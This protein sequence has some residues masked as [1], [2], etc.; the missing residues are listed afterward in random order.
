MQNAMPP[1][2]SNFQL[3]S[4]VVQMTVTM[5]MKTRNWLRKSKHF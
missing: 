2:D 1:V 5:I 3:Q 4:S